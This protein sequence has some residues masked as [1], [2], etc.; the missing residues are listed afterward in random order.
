MNRQEL[1]KA[2]E[3]WQEEDKAHRSILIIANEVIDEA[4]VAHSS[5][6][7]AGRAGNI[8]TMLKNALKNDKTLALFLNKA[9]QELNF[10]KRLEDMEFNIEQT[11]EE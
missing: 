7:M 4:N 2:F 6:G 11:E 9:V 10:E 3:Q 8:V 1:L 5:Q